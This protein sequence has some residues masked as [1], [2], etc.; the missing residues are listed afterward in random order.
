MTLRFV[1]VEGEEVTGPSI[2]EKNEISVFGVLVTSPL[3]VFN[4]LRAFQEAN[5]LRGI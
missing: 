4:I 3:Q 2:Y 5:I 1:K